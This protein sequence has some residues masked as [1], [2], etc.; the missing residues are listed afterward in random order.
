MKSRDQILAACR[1]LAHALTRVYI[2]SPYSTYEQVAKKCHCSRTTIKAILDGERFPR[3]DFIEG[4][5]AVCVPEGVDRER[6]LAKIRELWQVTFD[7]VREIR[8]SRR[9]SSA[10]ADQV[11]ETDIDEQV[12]L[13]SRSKEQDAQDLADFEKSLVPVTFYRNNSKFYRA[14]AE[15]AKSASSIMRL[16]YVRQV[17]PTQ[18]TS[19]E[20]AEYFATVLEWARQPGHRFVLRVIGIPIFNEVPEP[21]MLSWIKSH[22]LDVQEI[23]NYEARIVPWMNRGDGLNMALFDEDAVFV[24]VSGESRQDLKGMAFPDRKVHQYFTAHFTQLW[25]N[26]ESIQRFIQRY[27]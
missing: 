23:L 2:E 13:A 1:S 18:V 26:A 5:V 6:Q 20:A 19:R 15:Y 25:H 22:H 3:R 14:A 11:D 4:F 9:K 17:P 24:A 10:S 21:Q 8:L 27:T 16:T 7:A 12:S